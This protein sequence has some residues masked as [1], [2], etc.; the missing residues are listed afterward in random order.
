MSYRKEEYSPNLNLN[1]QIAEFLKNL[2][3]T[4]PKDRFNSGQAL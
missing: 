4:N 2:I 1:P 3:T